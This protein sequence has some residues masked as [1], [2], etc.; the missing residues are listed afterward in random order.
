MRVLWISHLLPYPP[1]G[2]VRQR[3][4]NLVRM[5]ARG[6]ELHVLALT[7]RA[8]HA[9]EDSVA[10]AVEAIRSVGARVE[11]FAIP[12]ESSRLRWWTLVATSFARPLPYS[13]NWLR[14]Q[15]M[16]RRM[17]DL[18]TDRDAFDVVH[19]DTIGLAEF[20][21]SLPGVPMVL[22]HHN[23]ES[24]M[25][26]R[27]ASKESNPAK[28][29]YFAREARKLGR[30]ER[31]ACHRARMNLV[32]SDLDA[33]RLASSVGPTPTATIPNGV[34]VDY[35]RSTREPGE[36]CGGFVFVGGMDWYPNREAVRFL[37]REIWPVLAEDDP[38]RRLTVV[39]RNPPP[40]LVRLQERDS[41]VSVPGFVDDVRPIMD[42]ALAYLCPIRDGGGT[43]LKVL[44]ALAM[45]KPLVATGLAVE[46]LDLVD[47]IHYLRAESPRDYL[48]Q[49]RRLESDPE[50]RRRLA[51]EARRFVE[52]RYSWEVIGEDLARAYARAVDDG[53]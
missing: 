21:R 17:E 51:T 46:G 10:E 34:D 2:G 40:D 41:R 42:D 12:S 49:V 6:H 3:S 4:Y 11:A 20:A 26:R 22:N 19:V 27:R 45:A 16:R 15:A 36:G 5:A 48:H 31:T 18:V 38:H 25:M 53:R 24:H 9:D 14:S 23:V 30:Y 32:V 50:L 33:E 44:D 52:Q 35:F 37:T 43:R 47:G 8:M 7:Q 29:I 28:R 13:V 1:I 39:G